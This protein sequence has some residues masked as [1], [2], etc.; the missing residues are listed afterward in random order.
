MC[1]LGS[2]NSNALDGTDLTLLEDGYVG[3]FFEAPIISNGTAVPAIAGMYYKVLTGSITYNSVVYVQN[4]EF[5]TN[6]TQTSTS[7]TTGTF[8]LTIPPALKNEI[9][10]FTTEIFAQKH[11]IK[12]NEPYD[13]YTQDSD[14]YVPRGSLT[15]ADADYFGWTE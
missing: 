8:A 7:G 1:G 10:D 6:G 5:V 12:G 2:L 11:L 13:Y 15:C 3:K 4:E 9:T 14:G